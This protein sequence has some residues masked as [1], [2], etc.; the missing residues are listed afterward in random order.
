M[1]DMEALLVH[2]GLQGQERLRVSL[3]LAGIGAAYA[4][5]LIKSVSVYMFHCTS[6][7]KSEKD[8]G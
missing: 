7:T 2:C 3:Y 1:R 4:L 6:C 8:T 5:Y